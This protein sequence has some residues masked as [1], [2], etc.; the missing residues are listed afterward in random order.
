MLHNLIADPAFDNKELFLRHMVH[1]CALSL[2]ALNVG[3]Y[4]RCLRVFFVW[5]VVVL[6]FGFFFNKECH[7]MNQKAR[8]LFTYIPNETRTLRV[9][10]I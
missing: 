4:S 7:Y 8:K 2:S 10:T 1:R 5:L 9:R 6:F 3:N